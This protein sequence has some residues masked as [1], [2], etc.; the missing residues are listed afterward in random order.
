MTSLLWYDLE[1]WNS[2]VRSARIAQFAAI[3]TDLDFNPIA[4]PIVYYCAPA[5]DCIP[6]PNAVL[7]HQLLPSKLPPQNTLSE[8]EMLQRIQQVMQQP[9]TVICGYNNTRF[10]NEVL[11]FSWF[12]SA[13]DAYAIDYQEENRWDIIDTVRA[14]HALRPEGIYWQKNENNA[15]SFRLEILAKAN[16]IDQKQA[17]NALSD[18]YATIAMAKLLQTKQP[19]LYD[20]FFSHR[21]KSK[22]LKLF[23]LEQNADYHIQTAP[24][25]MLVHISGMISD[26]QNRAEIIVPIAFHPTYKNEI[27][28]FGIKQNPQEI[29]DLSVEQIRQ[30]VFSSNEQL[31]QKNQQRLRICSI[32]LKK[33]PAIA[34]LSV[35]K[36]ADCWHKIQHNQEQCDKN[37]Q[38]LLKNFDTIRNKLVEL[39]DSSIF[40]NESKIDV[41]LSLYNNFLSRKDKR[42][43]T[44]FHHHILE[45]RELFTFDFDNSELQKILFRVR[46]R[47][48]PQTLN[49]EEQNTWN[50]YCQEEHKT[51]NATNYS[52]QQCQQEIAELKKTDLEPEKEALLSDFEQW[53]HQHTDQTDGL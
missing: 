48:A 52:L 43:L 34:P 11:R 42:L 41:D 13:L 31:A 53:V 5:K 39:Y 17:H 26:Q 20:F 27:I 25:P 47:N 50:K 44:Q 18:V 28:A 7:V 3:K 8:L 24:P 33:V 1:T 38:L 45:N 36:K 6:S 30:R 40:E 16:Q 14:C 19:K 37:Y 21:T 35:L 49:Q 4:D 22:Q 2:N 29:L 9:N 32:R 10:D 46:A 23:R 51:G 15:T 12:R